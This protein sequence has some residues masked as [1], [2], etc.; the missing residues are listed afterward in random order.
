MRSLPALVLITALLAAFPATAQPADASVTAP[1][2]LAWAEIVPG[3]AF[4]PLYGDWQAEAHGKFVR[5]AGDLVSPMHTHTHPYHGVVVQGLVI[6]PYD[7]DGDPEIMGPG[8][9]F[10]VPGGTPH[11]TGCVSAEPCLFYTHGDAGWDLE[12]T[13]GY[14]A[15]LPYEVQ[16]EP[17]AMTVERTRAVLEAYAAE[18]DP[19]HLAEDAVF[20]DLATG[21]RYEGR[22]A[23]GEMLHHIYHVAFD[24]RAEDARMMVGEGS[25]ALEAMFVGTHTGEF[26]GIPATGREVRV[27][28]ARYAPPAP[29]RRARPRP[30]PRQ[31]LAR[32]G[33]A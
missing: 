29:P 13:D 8:T 6:N 27:P 24:A 15:E 19:Q 26:A 7:D 3:L 14:P 2:A 25:A 17:G 16:A 20:I 5:F 1:D 30:D 28:L 22:E 9:H 10:Y 32:H 23:I 21:Q 12:M 11:R 4:A 18:H 31:L 33:R